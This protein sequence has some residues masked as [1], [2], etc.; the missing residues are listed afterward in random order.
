M[1]NLNCVICAELFG[2]ADEVFATVCGHMFHHSCLN[3]WLDRSKTCPQCRNKCTTRNIFRVYFN[4]AN[5]DVSRIDVGSLQ[6]QLDNAKLSMKMIEKERSKDEQQMRNLKETQKKCLKTIAGLEQ[7]VQKKEF[8]IS[9]YAEQISIL[10]SDAHVVD[11]L[12]KE[13]KSLKSQIQ[14]MEGVSAILAAGSADAERLLKNEADPNVLANWV[15]TLKREL[16]QCESKKTELRNVVKLVQNDLRKEIE[17][18][19]KLEERVSS[20]ESDLYQA[21]EKLNALEV[22]TICLDSP[23]A[24]CGLNSNIF[25]LKREER[26]T[27]I[28]PTVKENIK[29]IEESTSPYLNIKSSS[30]AWAAGGLGLSKSKLSPIKGVGGVTMTS[31]TIRKTNSDLSEKYSIFKKPRLLLGS[32]SGSGLAA[33]TSSN[34]VYNGM[35]GSEKIDPFAQ[36]AEEEGPASGRPSAVLSRN[37]NQRLKAGSLRNFNLGK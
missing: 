21:Q 17:L 35:G 5:L 2:Q 30:V 36:R 20:L 11:G 29:R 19:R 15:S 14:A 16:R 13:N 23:N 4:L 10:K 34:F 9:S 12:R 6:E 3:Q 33:T 22:K 8:L 31:G 1:L 28:S 32:S 7:K 27:T 25:A 37:V 26:R 18:K 24:S